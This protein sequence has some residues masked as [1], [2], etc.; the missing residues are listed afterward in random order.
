LSEFL[1]RIPSAMLRWGASSIVCSN[2]GSRSKVE[3]DKMDHTGLIE[4]GIRE[5]VSHRILSPW[6][7]VWSILCEAMWEKAGK[8]R[9]PKSE[10]IFFKWTQKTQ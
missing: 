7:S 9:K 1:P 5:D 4:P 8:L 6:N 10:S 3:R 2:R